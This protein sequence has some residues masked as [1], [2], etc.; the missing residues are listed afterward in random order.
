M[1][2]LKPRCIYSPNMG[3]YRSFDANKFMYFLKKNNNIEL[4]CNKKY[5]KADWKNNTKEGFQ[6]FYTS[7]ISIIP[8]K[9]ILID[10]VYR[11]DENYYPKVVLG[12]MVCILVNNILTILMEIF[13]QKFKWR[14]LNV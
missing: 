3:S 1:H 4:I 12:K 7:N 13:Q 11:N 5:L 10:S 6:W 2:I 14:K 9:V 8:I